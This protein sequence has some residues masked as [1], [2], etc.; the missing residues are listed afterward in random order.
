MA[1]KR[2]FISYSWGDPEHETM[3]HSFINYLREKGFEAEFDKMLSQNETAINFT[4]MMHLAMSNSYDKVIIVLSESYKSKAELFRGGVGEEYSLL[5][6]DINNAVN[7]YVFFSFGPISDAIV[8]FGLKGREVIS[9]TSPDWEDRLLAKLLDQPRYTFSDIAPQLP[10]VTAQN[11]PSFIAEGSQ[12]NAAENSSLLDPE[13]S[14]QTKQL[15][16]YC[17][18][19]IEIRV[20]P[21]ISLAR[22]MA[23][24]ESDPVRSLAPFF[25]PAF[26]PVFK[27]SVSSKEIRFKTGVQK[28]DVSNI[29]TESALLIKPDRI[30]YEHTDYRSI[31]ILHTLNS[32]SAFI[33]LM[34]SLI[35]ALHKGNSN[36]VSVNIQVLS[37]KDLHFDFA[38]NIFNPQDFWCDYIV[39]SETPIDISYDLVP[40]DKAGLADLIVDLHAHFVSKGGILPGT[41]T[42]LQLDAAPI[43]HKIAEIQQ[44]LKLNP[45]DDK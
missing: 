37:N 33:I 17:Y 41:P 18:T 20:D 25:I 8:P 28:T 22:L 36:K 40:G 38:R 43:K 13:H 4:K 45:T 34:D 1:S 16:N 23:L 30:Q 24:L 31:D 9:K 3:I 26:N 5:I 12:T 6:N 14:E 19:K 42:F 11:A 35:Y 29:T 44:Q 15:G 2:V 21:A 39:R 10:T 7:K 27:Q 32:E